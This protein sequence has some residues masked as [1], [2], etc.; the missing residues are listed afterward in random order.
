MSS[1]DKNF[2]TTV[3]SSKN[4]MQNYMDAKILVDYLQMDFPGVYFPPNYSSKSERYEQD[5]AIMARNKDEIMAK[6][7][8]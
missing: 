7:D 3:L 1:I 8:D 4:V 5:L 2:F 6:L